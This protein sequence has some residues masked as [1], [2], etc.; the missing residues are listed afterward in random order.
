MATLTEEIRARR[1]AVEVAR[2]ELDE[3]AHELA[4]ALL[5]RLRMVDGYTLRSLK[6]ALANFDANRK[7]WKR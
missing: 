6:R 4:V 2:R 5:P 7:A 3:A 1:R